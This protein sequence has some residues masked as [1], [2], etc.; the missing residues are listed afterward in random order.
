MHRRIRLIVVAAAAHLAACATG[1]HSRGFT[2][3]FSETQLDRDVWA[4]SFRG[5][6]YTS[7]ERASDFVLLRSA[8][9][10]LLGCFQYFII[11]DRENLNTF[12]TYTEPT[13]SSTTSNV[14]VVG[15]TAYGS[16]H[17]TT[18][19]GQTYVMRK[20]G[21]TN[22]IICFAE[23]PNVN[24]VVYDARFIWKSIAPKYGVQENIP[25][26]ASSGGV[27]ASVTPPAP[28]NVSES[29]PPA[30]GPFQVQDTAPA[31]TGCTKDTDCKGDRICESSACVEPPA[32]L[33]PRSSR[34]ERPRNFDFYMA[35]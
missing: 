20:P 32:N 33:G 12:Q 23:R 34:P 17:T 31:H 16:S 29:I 2:G 1:Y 13:T 21:R 27:S 8:E 18:Y 30:T 14:S 7:D 10:A 11:V 26:V 25:S 24:G 35:Q 3:G 9:L 22:T 4:V 28:P 19:G 15:N 5:N 6:G